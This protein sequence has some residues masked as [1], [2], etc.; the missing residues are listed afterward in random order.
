MASHSSRY[1]P[2]WPTVKETRLEIEDLESQLAQ[3]RSSALAAARQEY[4]FTRDRH[5]RLKAAVR[6]QRLLVDDLNE[7]SIQ[8]NILKREVIPALVPGDTLIAILIDS[9]SYQKE[10]VAAI[11]T[12]DARPSRANAQKLALSQKLESLAQNRSRARYTTSPAR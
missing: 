8:Y 4:E 12:L 1:G 5:R 10:N 6:D 7:R 3:E 2:E 9:Q 11:A